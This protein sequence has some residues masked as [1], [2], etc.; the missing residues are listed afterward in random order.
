MDLNTHIRHQHIRHTLWLSFFGIGE[1]FNLS[2]HTDTHKST[3]AQDVVPCFYFLCQTLRVTCLFG[4]CQ[5]RISFWSAVYQYLI[6][7]LLRS[8]RMLQ[9]WN[10]CLK[11]CIQV[12]ESGSSSP[13]VNLPGSTRPL[14]KIPS[15]I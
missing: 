11:L 6:C 12:D 3:H 15:P 8:T 2:T 13:R 14:Y 4:R 10:G 9:K 1:G 5:S 7:P